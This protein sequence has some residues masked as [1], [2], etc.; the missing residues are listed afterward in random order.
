MTCLK[1]IHF[2]SWWRI[3]GVVV[4]MPDFIIIISVFKLPLEKLGTSLYPR[5]MK[6]YHGISTLFNNPFVIVVRVF[7][8][9]QVEE[10]SIPNRII[11]NTQKCY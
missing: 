10:G 4:N 8:D 2:L 1:I 3:Y 5:T 11:S 7:A 9:G 6:K